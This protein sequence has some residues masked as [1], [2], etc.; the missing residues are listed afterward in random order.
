MNA[1]MRARVDG[2]IHGGPAMDAASARRRPGFGVPGESDAGGANLDAMLSERLPGRLLMELCTAPE[3]DGGALTA[4]GAALATLHTQE[5]PDLSCWTRE[6]ETTDLL[7]L[8]KEISFICP[9]LAQRAGR[10]HALAAFVFHE[11]HHV[12]PL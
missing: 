10:G 7:S 8:S 1:K 12:R 6:A 2:P 5:A 4:A 3:M 9:H 11:H